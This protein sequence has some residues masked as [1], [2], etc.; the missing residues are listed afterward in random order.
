MSAVSQPRRTAWTA[1]TTSDGLRTST[2]FAPG[3]C[4]WMRLSTRLNHAVVCGVDAE[5]AVQLRKMLLD[6]GLGNHERSGDLTN[7]GGLGE[8]ITIE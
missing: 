1:S 2:I 3:A 4:S 6:R 8:E 5:L 7:R